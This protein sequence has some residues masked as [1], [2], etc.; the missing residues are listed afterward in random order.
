VDYHE[1]WVHKDVRTHSLVA[2]W[3]RENTW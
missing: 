1:F 3:G 2:W